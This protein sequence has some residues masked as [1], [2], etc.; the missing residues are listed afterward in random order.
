MSQGP[1][2]HRQIRSLVSHIFVL[3]QQFIL[4]TKD[5][6]LQF[7]FFFL[8]PLF[9]QHKS[10]SNAYLSR[11]VPFHPEIFKSI[12]KIHLHQNNE[13]RKNCCVEFFFIYIL[14]ILKKYI[15]CLP[16]ECY[17]H[18]LL[19]VTVYLPSIRRDV[20]ELVI[21]K[22]LQLD[23]SHSESDT[24]EIP[25]TAERGKKIVTTNL[26]VCVMHFRSVLLGQILRTQST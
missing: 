24:M 26:C 23:V 22:M 10:L 3:L 4:G 9:F 7:W 8:G 5:S 21:G 18:N 6:L 20:L 16:Q 19:R 14:Y 13:A 15:Y 12:G 17:V 25:S 1:A 2:A 11:K